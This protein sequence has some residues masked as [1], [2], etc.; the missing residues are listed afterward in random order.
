MATAGRNGATIHHICCVLRMAKA[1]RN[2]ATIQQM[3]C[4]LRM[5]K[6]G[7]NGATIHHIGGYEAI[8][9]RELS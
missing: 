2:G 4:V 6:A 1:G 8:A 7:R 3:C 5:A 9:S